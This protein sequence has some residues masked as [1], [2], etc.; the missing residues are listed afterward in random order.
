MN[1]ENMVDLYAPLFPG[2]TP[3]DPEKPAY[4]PLEWIQRFEVFAAKAGLGDAAKAR[5]ARWCLRG[6]AATYFS[7]ILPQRLTEQEMSVV[8]TN[9]AGEGGF[10]RYFQDQF[11]NPDGAAELATSWIATEQERDELETEFLE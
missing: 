11:L 4:L 2:P 6:T 5:N 8:E 9:W 7:E 10:L 1:R 3:S